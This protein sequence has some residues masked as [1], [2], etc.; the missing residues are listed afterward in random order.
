MD[1]QRKD[2]GANP[3]GISL[4]LPVFCI[5]ALK[6]PRRADAESAGVMWTA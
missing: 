2:V 1:Q 5:L 6:N 4:V 3:F